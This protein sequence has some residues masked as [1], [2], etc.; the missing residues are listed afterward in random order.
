MGDIRREEVMALLES[1]ESAI[2]D[3][4]SIN[5]YTDYW[6]N[7]IIDIAIEDDLYSCKTTPPNGRTRKHH[8]MIEKL[9]KK[10]RR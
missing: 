6:N 1:Y 2:C 3:I 5:K 7:N 4:K 8:G 9:N 10:R